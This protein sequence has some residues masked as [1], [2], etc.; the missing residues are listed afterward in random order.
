M[1]LT[2]TIYVAPNKST[3][4]HVVLPEPWGLETIASI[5][6][7]SHQL[8]NSDETPAKSTQ[9]NGIQPSGLLGLIFFLHIGTSTADIV[10]F[11]FTTTAEFAGFINDLVHPIYYASGGRG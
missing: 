8:T 7:I 6:D 1:I 11:N 9:R 10:M 2:V 3:Q 4:V 5:P